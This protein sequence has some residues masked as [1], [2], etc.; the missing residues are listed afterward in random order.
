MNVAK[1]DVPFVKSHHLKLWNKCTDKKIA[2]NT[3]STRVWFVYILYKY[4]F[5]G[6]I[7]MV[8]IAE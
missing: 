2:H 3:G 5:P 6:D 1:K 4:Y 8:C 7:F